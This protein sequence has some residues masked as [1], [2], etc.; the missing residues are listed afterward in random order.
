MKLKTN[1]T[2][3]TINLGYANGW[4]NK[5]NQL[6]DELQKNKVVGSSTSENVGRCL[7]VYTFETVYED[8]SVLVI[9]KVDSSD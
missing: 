8:E 5:D 6:Y 7:N 1:R 9:Y 4:G 2:M 3:K